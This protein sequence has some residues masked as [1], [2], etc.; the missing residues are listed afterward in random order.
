MYDCDPLAGW[1][2]PT[3]FVAEPLPITIITHDVHRRGGQEHAT[4]ELVSRLV[5]RGRFVTVIARTC[6]LPPSSHLN[7]IRVPGPRRP[8]PLAYLWF[9]LVGTL[10]T[11]FRGRGFRQSVGAIVLN[12]VDAASVHFC[13]YGYSKRPTAE[14]RRSDSPLHV[15]AAYLSSVLSRAAERWCYR[16]GHTGT[17]VAVSQGVA[18]ELRR[19]FP[20]MADRVVVIPNGVDHEQ[21]RPDPEARVRIRSEAGLHEDDL[22]AVF[23]GGD[24]ERKGLPIA[25]R[26][27]G[28]AE[29]WHLLVA[30][31]GDSK[32]MRELAADCGAD[33]RVHLL[34][35]TARPSDIYAAGDAFVLPSAY[36]SFSLASLEA[37]AT[38][39]P[40][41]RT[42]VNGAAELLREGENGFVIDREPD[43]VRDALEKLAADPA[44]CQ[45]MASSARRVAEQYGWDDVAGAYE[46]IYEA[47]TGHLATGSER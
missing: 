12:R 29:R 10:A 24:W 4:F 28:D 46:A 37:A 38:G 43:S 13:H 11:A 18:E 9:F 27:I 31:E 3:G 15:I 5:E 14:R 42:R 40:L 41:L 7:W 45:N 21:F 39:L 25:V 2:H 33:E 47:E 44:L 20:R 6:E 30:G 22:A 17:L 23:V 34:G 19:N 35:A 36:E 1:H 8:F 16:R 32:R 26:A